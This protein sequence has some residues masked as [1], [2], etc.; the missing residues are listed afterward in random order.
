MK[1]SLEELLSTK[2]LILLENDMPS[3]IVLNLKLNQGA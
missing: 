3:E 2:K 1:W